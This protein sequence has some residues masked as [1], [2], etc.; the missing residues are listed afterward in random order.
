M[1]REQQV[2]RQEIQTSTLSPMHTH[3]GQAIPNLNMMEEPVEAHAGAPAVMYRDLSAG[4]GM[5]A[6]SAPAPQVWGN[7]YPSSQEASEPPSLAWPSME[8]IEVPM[9]W[10]AN[11]QPVEAFAPSPVGQP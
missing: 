7:S 6:N 8:E 3:E 11:S 2:F 5:Q 4:Q 1:Q 10:S 9:M